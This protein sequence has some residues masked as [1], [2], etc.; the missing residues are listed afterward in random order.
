MKASLLYKGTSW[1]VGATKRNHV[2]TKQN[3]TSKQASKQAKK[4][5]MAFEVI[6]LKAGGGAQVQ[7]WG[8]NREVTWSLL[9]ALLQD[10]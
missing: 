8:S 10:G 2:S 6:L 7:V 5:Q 1:I 4:P 3:N 9:G